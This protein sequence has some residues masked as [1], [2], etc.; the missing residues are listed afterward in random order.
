MKI[1]ILQCDHV[2]EQFQ[3]TFGDYPEMIATLFAKVSAECR[4]NTYQVQ[5]LEYPQDINE[6][7]AY[8]TT[9]SRYS[10]NDDYEWVKRLQAFVCELD[11]AKKPLLVFA[12][13]TN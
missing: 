7:D 5:T 8:I 1:G 13:D 4:F 11:R 3:P 6:C 2:L 10:V 9:G 12:L